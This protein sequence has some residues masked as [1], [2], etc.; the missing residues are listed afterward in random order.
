ME[1]DDLAKFNGNIEEFKKYKLELEKTFIYKNGKNKYSGTMINNLYEGRGILYNDNEGF[2]KYN[3]YFKKGEYD[4]FGI[5]YQGNIMYEGFFKNNTFHGKGILY[6]NK[7]KKYEGF[8]LNGKYD[9]I[10]IEYT[11]EGKRKR[12]AFYSKGKI[13][14]KCIG[15]LYDENDKEIYNGSLLDGKPKEGNNLTI[16]GDSDYI[17][18]IG[19]FSSFKYNGKGIL[20]Y[21]NDDK[22][23]YNGIFKD[24]L[25]DEGILYYKD[26]YKKYEGKFEDNK[27]EGNGIL[28]FEMGNKIFYKGSFIKGKFNYGIIYSP[29][30]EILYEGE[31]TNNMPKEGK[32]IKLYKINGNLDYEGDIFN[33][34]YNGNGKIYE[35]NIIKFKGIFKDGD[36]IKGILYENSI[37]KYEGEF[38]NDKFNGH[39]KIYE[40][41][42]DNDNY[43]YYEGNFENDQIF[44]KGI[45]YYKNGSKK[46]EGY[47]HNINSYKGI[48]YNPDN[49]EILFKDKVF[50][51][52]PFKAEHQILYNDKGNLIYASSI[53]EEKLIKLDKKTNSEI[54]DCNSTSHAVLLSIGYPGK[55]CILTRLFKN[56]YSENFLSTIG[57]DKEIM[58]YKYQNKYYKFTIWDTSGSERYWN[59][60]K[61]YMKN[62]GIFIIAIDLSIDIESNEES[63]QKL[64]AEIKK[65]SKITHLIYLVGNKLDIADIE[66]LEDYRKIAKLLIDKGKI[67]KYFEVS[68]KTGEGFNLFSKIL[69]IDSALLGD[70]DGTKDLFLKKLDNKYVNYFKEHNLTKYFNF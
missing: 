67:D 68:A 46:I 57:I 56:S 36:K 13:S 53:Y 5:L 42:N 54:K 31:F 14:N 7:K 70:F 25:Y 65:D 26:G 69:K 47:F 44:G 63:I 40:I 9:G 49:K 1:K 19:D 50:C 43:L 41:D 62:T 28:Y 24:D 37:K 45:K 64:L 55:T 35:S 15:I 48:Y 58:Y 18:Y 29:Y 39:G 51:E 4:G 34:L 3:G 11:L 30:K 27:Y 16:Y 38:K 61:K 22:V 21:E 6:E 20:Y 52:I 32:N 17:L 8:F 33:F 23:R 66:L 59:Q 2:I 12:K 60:Y 10:G